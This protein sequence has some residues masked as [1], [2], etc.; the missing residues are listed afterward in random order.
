[1]TDE[2]RYERVGASAVLT[3]D[4]QHRR[5]AV[6]GSTAERLREGLDAFE[7]D[8]EARVLVLTGAGDVAFCA[9]ADLK[10]IETYAPRMDDPGGPLGFTRLTPSKP[11]IAAIGGWGPP[12]RPQLAPWGGPR[13]APPSPTPRLPPPRRGGSPLHRGAPPPPPGV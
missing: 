11:T 13:G 9:G 12:R 5:N 3:I 1:M 6:D 7:A 10:A 8:D 4:R 2:V